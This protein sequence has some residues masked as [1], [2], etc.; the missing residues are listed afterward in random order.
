MKK[1]KLRFRPSNTIGVR[2]DFP[3]WENGEERYDYDMGNSLKVLLHSILVMYFEL[4][5]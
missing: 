1:V 2:K 4:R 5:A 3:K